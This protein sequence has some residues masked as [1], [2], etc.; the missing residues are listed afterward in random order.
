MIVEGLARPSVRQRV[1]KRQR[2][3]KESVD[4]HAVNEGVAFETERLG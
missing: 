1:G 2:Y 4:A 3:E